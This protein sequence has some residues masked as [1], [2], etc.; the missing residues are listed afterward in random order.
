MLADASEATVRTLKNPNP[1]TI[2][3]VVRRLIKERLEDGQ[4]DESNLTLRELDII[5]RTFTRVLTGVFHQRIEYPDR[6]LKEM[7]R[8]QGHGNR[9]GKPP[10]LVR[11]VGDNRGNGSP[12]SPR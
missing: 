10:R 7:E 1:Q 12:R 11:R 2:E 9:G 4:L 3:Q 5:A 8:S 6:V